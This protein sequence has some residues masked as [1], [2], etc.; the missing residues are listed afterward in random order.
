MRESRFGGSFSNFD[1]CLK[2]FL[3]FFREELSS[4]LIIDEKLAFLLDEDQCSH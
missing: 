2:D 4:V 3:I 1:C